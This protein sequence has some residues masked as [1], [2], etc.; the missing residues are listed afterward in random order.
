MSVLTHMKALWLKA[1]GLGSARRPL[2]VRVSPDLVSVHGFSCRTTNDLEALL[3][4]LR[5]AHVHVR[6]AS[7][8][9]YRHVAQAMSAVQKIGAHAGVVGSERRD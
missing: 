1:L 6:P 7:T 2:M 4:A 5:P 8:A 9:E 3:L